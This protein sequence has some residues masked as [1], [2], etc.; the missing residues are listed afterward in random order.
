MEFRFSD[1][2]LEKLYTSG[3]GA[4]NYPAGVVDS[5]LRRVRHIDAAKDE[6]DLRVPVSVHFEKLKGDYEGK[7][8]MRLKDRWRLV[9]RIVIEEGRKV[10]V[11]D[12]I[13]QH[14]GD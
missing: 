13:T 4:R 12:E 9:L 14:Y 7:Y 10:V 6:R 3:V 2:K 5:F 11:I 1:A 8:S